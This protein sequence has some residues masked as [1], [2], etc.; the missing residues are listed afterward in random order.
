[1]HEEGDAAMWL[2]LETRRVMASFLETLAR[3]HGLQRLFIVSPWI[4]DF[5]AE[6][7]MTFAQVLKRVKDDDA[8]AYVVSRPPEESWHR[9]AIETIAATGKANIALVPSLHTKLY[10]ADTDQGSF[11]LMGSAN[12]TE[13][14]LTNREIGVLLRDSGPGKKLVQDLKYEASEIYRSVGR[15]LFCQQKFGSQKK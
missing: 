2:R 3:S 9:V 5:G 14:S 7:G 8:T 1:M 4:S 11:A 12:F 6:G 10:C 13:K 15:K